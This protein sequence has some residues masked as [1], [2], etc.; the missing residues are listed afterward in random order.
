[1][2]I[3]TFGLWIPIWILIAILT[4]INLLGDCT[5]CGT[6]QS[7]IYRFISTIPFRLGKLIGKFLKK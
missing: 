4:G 3:I 5:E 2:S 6:P 1:L 7:I